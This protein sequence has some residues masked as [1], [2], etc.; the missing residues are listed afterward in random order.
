MFKYS[1]YV[2]TG[3]PNVEHR[4]RWEF[5]EQPP[6]EDLQYMLLDLIQDFLQDNHIS[7]HYERVYTIEDLHATDDQTI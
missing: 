1:W 2:A 3:V 6:Q 4:G 5:D 7:A